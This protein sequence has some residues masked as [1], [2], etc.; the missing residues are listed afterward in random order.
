MR[1]YVRLWQNLYQQ[2]V[3][4]N[5]VLPQ[6]RDNSYLRERAFFEFLVPPD[7]QTEAYRHILTFQ[8]W[9]DST[10]FST[11]LDEGK[12]QGGKDKGYR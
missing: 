3:D 6:G 7:E 9:F 2:C 12:N 10:L 8:P 4:R 5:L 11:F 1:N